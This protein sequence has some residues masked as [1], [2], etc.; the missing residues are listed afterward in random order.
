MV[1]ATLE[2]DN[3][4]NR[5]TALIDVYKKLRPGEPATVEGAIAHI[6]NLF[7][8][9]RTY[10][11]TR[12]GRY[13]YNKKLALSSRL[14]GKTLARPIAD[15]R[16]GEILAEAGETVN[17]E[18]ALE[19]EAKGVFEAYITLD[20]G[21]EFRIFSNGMVDM[22]N[23]V[24]FDPKEIGINE[25]VKFSVLCEILD[26]AK[27]EKEIRELAE[28]RR[29]ELLPMTV[30]NEDLFSSI[31]YLIGLFHNIG[32]SDDID[33]LGNRRIRSIGELLQNQMRIGFTRM[34]RSVKERMNM[35]NLD[36]VTPQN[37]I[38]AR[39]VIAAIREFFGSSPLSQF[40]DQP[41]PLAGLTHKRRL[42]A[43]GPGRTYERQSRIRRQRRSL[44]SLRKNVPGRNP[45]RPEH[46][47]YFLPGQL[48]QNKRIRLYRSPLPQDK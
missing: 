26:Q 38:N 23:F 9:E 29:S 15:P 21:K 33:H 25:K 13:K 35:Q 34:E 18:K 1:L 30:C 41:N 40:M 24:S 20:N 36:V 6:D 16:T 22:K 42:S 14:A 46:R 5:T 28:N 45:R 47:T 43:L 32:V 27:D 11:L 17:M 8:N 2:K 39:L 7:F 19:I 12:P 10:D 31:N 3:S 37:L 44:Y 4:T 48:R